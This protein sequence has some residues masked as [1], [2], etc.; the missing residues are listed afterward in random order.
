MSQTENRCERISKKKHN[1]QT[2]QNS[3]L[4]TNRQI[5]KSTNRE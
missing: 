1:K 5:Y 3:L 4:G 2:K